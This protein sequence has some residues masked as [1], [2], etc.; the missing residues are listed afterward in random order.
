[1]NQSLSAILIFCISL[2]NSAFAG[3]ALKREECINQLTVSTSDSK[4][5]I[6]P[7]IYGHFAEHL[8][9]CIYGGIWVGPDSLIPNVK[10]YRK[11]VLE[12]LKKLN[13]P[14]LR[15]P[16]GCFADEYHWKEGIGPAENRPSMLNTHWGR[17]TEDNSFGTHEFLTLC[18]MLGCH[19]YV[20]GNVGSGTVEEMQDWVEYMT[21]D[22]DSEMAQ[23]RR[24]N[25]RVKPWKVKYFGVGNENW[26]CGGNMTP[27]YYADL[28]KRFQT[29]VRNYSGN[30]IIK[31]A[32]GPG[33]RDLNWMK[34]VLERAHRRM[35]GISLHHYIRGTGNWS[36]KGSALDNR[37]SEWFALM[38]NSLSI[39]SLLEDNIT[40]LKKVDPQKRIGLY[41]DEWGT[42]WDQEPNTHPGFLFQ[43]NT[44]RDAVSAGIF[45]N[46]FNQRCDRVKMANIAQTVN[47]LQA[48]ILTKGNKMLLTPSYHVFEM[49][50]VHQ[51]AQLLDQKLVTCPYQH[52]AEKLDAL[53]VSASQAADG[54]IHIT[55]CHLNPRQATTLKCLIE[56]HEVQTVTGRV[57]TADKLNAHN[58]FDEPGRVKPKLLKGINFLRNTITC[59]LPAKSVVLLTIKEKSL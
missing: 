37:E 7:E 20:A 49:Y 46:E 8:G 44:L 51:G 58:T 56:G 2:F 24:T 38:K 18:E 3:P 12:A 21:Y 30:R 22:G 50:K 39:R 29:Y 54:T 16:G 6:A 43:Q 1:M 57:L 36:Q 59:T 33:G 15:W 35:G 48:M 55:I 9:R 31:I 4:A 42:W 25:G 13:I 5:T 26:G 19:A 23:L 40:I 11:D 52:G 41:V 17:V 45:L 10:G 32:C 34:V 28:Y 53:N 14:V 27:E 47:V